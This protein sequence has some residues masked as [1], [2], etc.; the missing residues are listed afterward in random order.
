VVVDGVADGHFFVKVADPDEGQFKH[1]DRWIL[2]SMVASAELCHLEGADG[3]AVEVLAVLRET[4]IGNVQC[5]VAIG[6]GVDQ[7]G[8]LFDMFGKGAA[9]APDRDVPLGGESLAD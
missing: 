5:E 7:F 9:F 4:S 1:G 8:E 6:L 3:N 2:V